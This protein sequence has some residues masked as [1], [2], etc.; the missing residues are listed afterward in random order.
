MTSRS[1][2]EASPHNPPGGF[3]AFW[4]RPFRIFFEQDNNVV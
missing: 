1:A 4:A 3:F 2:G